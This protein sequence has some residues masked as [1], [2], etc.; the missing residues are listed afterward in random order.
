MTSAE[1]AVISLI[2]ERPRH[3]YEIEQVIIERGMRQGV[4]HAFEDEATR[5]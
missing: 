3:A 2:V 5:A 4:R 1:L